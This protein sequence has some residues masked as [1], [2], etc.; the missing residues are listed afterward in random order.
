[1]DYDSNAFSLRETLKYA[2]VPLYCLRRS[3]LNLTLIYTGL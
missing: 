1:M 2:S 3:K